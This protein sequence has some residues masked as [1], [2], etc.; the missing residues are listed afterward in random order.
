MSHSHHGDEDGRDPGPSRGDLAFG[1]GV[2]RLCADNVAQ[3]AASRRTEGG[4]IG[5]P[6]MAAGPRT[7]QAFGAV[8]TVRR[9]GNGWLL[10]DGAGFERAALSDSS[11]AAEVVAWCAACTGLNDP[12]GLGVP[13]NRIPDT[14][15][16]LGASPPFMRLTV[17]QLANGWVVAAGDGTLEMLALDAAGVGG[18]VGDWMTRLPRASVGR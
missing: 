9:I 3:Q 18:I 16:S 8:L 4:V 12:R 13:G 11:A 10:E 2:G 7:M 5:R 1:P 6:Q 17:R 14:G 15:R